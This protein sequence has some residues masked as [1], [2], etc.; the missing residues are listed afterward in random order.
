MNGTFLGNEKRNSYGNIAPSKLNILWKHKL[1]S[2]TT[3]V[4]KKVVWSGAGWTGQPLMVLEN[5]RKYIIQGAYDHHLK[6]IDAETGKLIWQYKYDDV[7]KSTGTLWLNHNTDSLKYRCI[8]L[9]GSRAG[10]KL[11]AEKVFSYKAI[12]YFTGEKLWELN[13]VRT[14]SYSRDVDASAIIL[15][16]TAYIGLENSIFHIFNPNPR[17]ATIRDGFLQPEIYHNSDTLYFSSDVES[18]KGNLVTE[19]S[20]ILLGNRIYIASGSGHV[21]GYNLE[22]KKMDW[23]YFIGSDLNGT[24]AIT[25]DNCLLVPIEKQYIKGKG[26]IL[27]LNPALPSEQAGVWY[28]PTPNISFNSWKGGVFGSVTVKD[29]FAMFIG[30]DG[31][32][33]II[34]TQTM[35]KDSIKIFDGVRSLPTPKLVCKYYVGHSIST[36]L[37]V[38]DKI[39]AAGYEGLFLFQFDKENKQLLLLDK[40][41]IVCEA[42]PWVYDKHIYIAAKDGY[43]YS[44]GEK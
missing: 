38:E 16:D 17:H 12:S 4:K 21:W 29:N 24:P 9:Q 8:I 44:F 18:H 36:P 22:T 5:G 25:S 19:S 15:R 41:E 35:E 26:G 32:L 10:T 14:H 30:L 31:F 28:F 33:Y 42:T 43:L 3:Y 40:V 39:I 27:K 6:K 11:N 20:P 1:G 37:F 13:S 2:G 34:D 23:N 7:I